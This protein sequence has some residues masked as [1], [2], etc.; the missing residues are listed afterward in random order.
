MKREEALDVA[1]GQIERRGGRGADENEREG[2]QPSVH[3]NPL[4]R[5]SDE[6]AGRFCSAL[7]ANQRRLLSDRWYDRVGVR[8]TG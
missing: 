1:L 4:Q 6:F 8:V 3:R 7:W 5:V 2:W